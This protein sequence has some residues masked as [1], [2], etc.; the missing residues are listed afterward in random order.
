MESI[1]NAFFKPRI[2]SAGPTPVPLFALSAMASSVHYH[3]GPAFAEIMG[4]CRKLLPPVFGTS[5]EA[6]I[7]SGSGTLAMEGAIANF[8]NPGEEVVAINSGKFG[9]RWASQAK[10]YGLNVKEILVERGKAVNVDDVKKAVGP[11]TRGILIHASETSTSVRHN[12]KAIAQIANDQKNCLCMVDSVT[13]LGVFS[14]PMDKWGVDVMVGGSQKGFMLPPGLAFGASSKRAWAKAQEVKNVR[15]YLDWRKERKAA[16]ENSGAFTSPVTLIGGLRAV[17]E[18]MH[19]VGLE[20]IYKKNWRLCFAARAA[21]RAMGARLFVEND[22]EASAACTALYSEGIISGKPYQNK[23]KMTLS[24]GQDELKGKI[25]RIGHIG[26]MDAWDVCS[27][28]LATARIFEAS[29]KKINYDAV[30]KSF[31]DIAESEEDFTPE[32]LKA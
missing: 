24:G 13:S 15:Y 20:N 25:M 9:A 21:I 22:H 16:E 11:E 2:M 18:Y 1:K 27:Q 5:E 32:D 19:E 8:F 17:L 4:A 10:I 28:L 6:L 26:Y 31:M 23:Y 7:F 12:V 14:V 30:I 29:G 3:R